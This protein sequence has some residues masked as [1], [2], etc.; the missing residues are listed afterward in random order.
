[1]ARRD[2]MGLL[3]EQAG[4]QA[5]SQAGPRNHGRQALSTIALARRVP[6]ELF[7]LQAHSGSLGVSGTS[8][9][10]RRSL[11]GCPRG[12]S[13][14]SR[15]PLLLSAPAVLRPQ[16]TFK[17]H[18]ETRRRPFLRPFE[19]LPPSSYSRRCLLHVRP[20]QRC[21]RTSCPCLYLSPP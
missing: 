8:A 9:R 6:V 7:I 18:G 2:G 16:S 10:L 14:I 17:I 21:A 12:T 5:G 20:A 13:E 11:L 3:L 1:M 15:S 19:P 4:Q